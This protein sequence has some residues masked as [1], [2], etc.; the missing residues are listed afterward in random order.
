MAPSSSTSHSTTATPRRS[1]LVPGS[2]DPAT[3]ITK[4]GALLFSDDF[5][6]GKLAPN[7]DVIGGAW[8]VTDGK[9]VGS[10]PAD[11][12]D[13][14]VGHM[15]AG[16]RTVVQFSFSFTGTGALTESTVA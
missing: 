8:T 14:N 4:R 7:W 3:F 6:S 16:D 11:E 2:A 5:S 15:V 9:L 13:P 1:Q 12:R 10:S